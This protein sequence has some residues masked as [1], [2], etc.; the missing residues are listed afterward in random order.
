MNLTISR[1]YC[2]HVP[3]KNVP[4]NVSFSVNVLKGLLELGVRQPSSALTYLEDHA[5]DPNFPGITT[6]V[7][8][9]SH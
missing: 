8:I 5:I 9:N 1:P 3:V 6:A 2:T 4:L 7:R